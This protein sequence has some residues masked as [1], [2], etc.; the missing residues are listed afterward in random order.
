MRARPRTNI[1]LLKTG[2]K[3]TTRVVQ[4][5]RY[6]LGQ[7]VDRCTSLLE[8]HLD[9]AMRCPECSKKT[10]KRIE[11]ADL[12]AIRLVYQKTLPDISPEDLAEATAEP[13]TQ[14]Q[15]YA[16]ISGILLDMNL[17]SGWVQSDMA[18]AVKARDNLNHLLPDMRTIVQAE[19]HETLQ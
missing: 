8:G 1:A 18:S 15:I 11:K 2:E 17:L 9:Q 10:D 7:L 5:N 13:K 3:L 14:E 12:E 16:S 19:S 6:R 4:T